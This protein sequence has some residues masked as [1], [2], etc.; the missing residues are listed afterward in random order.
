MRI[1]REMKGLLIALGVSLLLFLGLYLLKVAVAPEPKT[2]QSAE[3]SPAQ[4]ETTVEVTSEGRSQGEGK[5]GQGK[6]TGKKVDPK[7][8][9]LDAIYDEDNSKQMKDH[10]KA[11]RES[12]R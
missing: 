5:P 7:Q 11:I 8:N 4:L 9:L 1:V 12:S 10:L 2:S 3:E 6:L